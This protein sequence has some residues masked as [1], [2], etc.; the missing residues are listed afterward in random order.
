MY[1]TMNLRQ[2]SGEDPALFQIT[3]HP[4]SDRI[5]TVDSSPGSKWFT[6]PDDRP[7]LH[8]SIPQRNNRTADGKHCLR[9][10]KKVSLMFI[11]VDGFERINDIFG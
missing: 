6:M 4:P 7:R 3:I 9:C 11:D 5:R 8:S 10:K 2:F 1:C